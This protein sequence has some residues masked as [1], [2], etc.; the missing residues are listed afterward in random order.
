MTRS[1]PARSSRLATRR[2]VMG[3][4]GAALRS[5]ARIA[6][7][8]DAGGDGAGG[9]ALR[10]IGRDEQLHE[11]VVH[12]ARD[13]LDEENVRAAH[14]LIEARIDLAVRELLKS[15]AGK[16]DPQDLCD[17]LCERAVRRSRVEAKRL[18]HLHGLFRVVF[19]H[20]SSPFSSCL[21]PAKRFAT[22]GRACARNSLL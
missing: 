13:G 11:G 6:V 10:R 9:C 20:C 16:L 19:W 7:V 17:L 15:K 8:R 5:W 2:A 12:I 1:T 14:R 18:H 4:R 22:Y 3:S 21:M